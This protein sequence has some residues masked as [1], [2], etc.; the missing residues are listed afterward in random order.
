MIR[1]DLPYTV[2][3]GKVLVVTTLGQQGQVS[4]GDVSIAVD[5]EA[6]RAFT[7]YVPPN[8]LPSGYVVEIPH[9]TIMFQ[10]NEEV[11]VWGIGS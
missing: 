3:P 2:P 10:P 7:Y 5:G 4:W 11:H 1:G 6:N 8:D 9:P